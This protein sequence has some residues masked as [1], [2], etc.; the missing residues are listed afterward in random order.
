MVGLVVAVVVVLVIVVIGL[1]I[2][3]LSRVVQQIPK[4]FSTG[5]I[6]MCYDIVVILLS[7]F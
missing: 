2:G 3:N 1:V 4:M 7:L 6:S 5:G